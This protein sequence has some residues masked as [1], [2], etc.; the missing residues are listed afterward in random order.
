MTSDQE[1]HQH[2]WAI[3]NSE[4]LQGRCV[5]YLWLAF[6]RK[7]HQP[8]TAKLTGVALHDYCR[9]KTLEHQATAQAWA[10]LATRVRPDAGPG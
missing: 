2:I 8:C 4:P 3:D 9:L 1:N 6:D 10:E 7:I 5:A